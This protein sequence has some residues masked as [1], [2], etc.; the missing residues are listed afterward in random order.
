MWGY[1]V[2]RPGVLSAAK[3]AVKIEAV[4]SVST[5][6]PLNTGELQRSDD[7]RHYI[8]LSQKHS[9]DIPEGRA[10]IAWQDH[11]LLDNAVEE[12]PLETAVLA[13][14]TVNDYFPSGAPDYQST[15]KSRSAIVARFASEAGDKLLLV[16]ARAGQH[17]NDHYAYREFVLKPTETGYKILQQTGFEFDIAGIEGAEFTFLSVLFLFFFACLTGLG[18]LLKKLILSLRTQRRSWSVS[19]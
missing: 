1:A 11:G 13:L 16:T 6:R 7:W 19:R 3:S 5:W 8:D 4:T 12:L 17:R 15:A 9:Y 10:L 14:N 2:T 18:L